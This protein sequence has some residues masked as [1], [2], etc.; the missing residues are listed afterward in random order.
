MNYRK[1]LKKEFPNVKPFNEEDL[2]WY[3]DGWDLINKG[4][5]L[6]AEVK[7]KMLTLSQPNH[8]DG[9][10][11]LARTY[12]SMGNKEKATFF[13]GEA[14]KMTKK[15]VAAGDSDPEILNM[16]KELKMQIEHMK[17]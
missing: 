14:I 15:M 16:M 5:L 9:L 3:N 13:I 2:E 4:K 17:Q 6:E 7:F 11:G 12:F 1:Q 8:P 10:E